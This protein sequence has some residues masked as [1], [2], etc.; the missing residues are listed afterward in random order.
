MNERKRRKLGRATAQLVMRS[1]DL[2]DAINILEIALV[3]TFIAGTDEE[4]K[5]DPE[6]VV[7]AMMALLTDIINRWSM[8]THLGPEVNRLLEQMSRDAD[9]TGRNA[10]N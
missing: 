1:M 7:R 3:E 9:W 2:P 6:S 5:A 10:V 8:E 4:V